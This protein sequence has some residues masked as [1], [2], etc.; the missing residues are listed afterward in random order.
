MK[1][2]QS[3]PVQ[4]PP[5]SLLLQLGSAACAGA[6]P[7]HAP[8]LHSVYVSVAAKLGVMSMGALGPDPSPL[9]LFS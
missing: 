2:K 1:K 9:R 8:T 3:E 6:R 4:Q 5:R 7:S